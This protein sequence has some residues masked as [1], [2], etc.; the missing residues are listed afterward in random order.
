[1]SNRLGFQGES[2]AEA[3]H[4]FLRDSEIVTF[5]TLVERI[6]KKGSWGDNTIW[7]HLMS[8]VLNLPPARFEWRSTKPFL[9]LHPDGRYELYDVSRHPRVVSD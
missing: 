9:F 4:D 2:C 6:K 1:V 5:T 8:C 7:R 3:I